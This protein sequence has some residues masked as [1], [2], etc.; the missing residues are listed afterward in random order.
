MFYRTKLY[1]GDA[2]REIEATST[3]PLWQQ[4]SMLV[5]ALKRKGQLL[6][7]LWLEETPPHLDI[8]KI[9]CLLELLVSFVRGGLYY[10]CAK[11]EELNTRSFLLV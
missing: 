9:V 10:I 1:V 11:L 7:Y 5:R 2:V 4:S 3:Q 6:T 8:V